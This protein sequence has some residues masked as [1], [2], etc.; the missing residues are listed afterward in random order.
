MPIFAY[1]VRPGFE[2]VRADFE[3]ALLQD[4][5]HRADSHRQ[6]A[7]LRKL[8]TLLRECEE[9]LNVALK[10]AQA[11]D[12]DRQLLKERI[13]GQ[14]SAV[15]DLKLA[16]HLAVKHA[17]A[18]TRVLNEKILG[19]HEPE[20]NTWLLQQFE[21]LF[22]QWTISLKYAAEMF[23]AWLHSALSERMAALSL[24]I[25]MISPNLFTASAGNYRSR[26]KISGIGS[27][28]RRSR[29]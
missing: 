7:L 28:M 10:S 11:A 17:K 19:K 24:C 12:S 8:E 20:L 23:E 6:A 5:L 4:S 15:Q 16:L 14:P 2:S 26:F 21:A 18:N 9:Y 13:L 27:P 29:P 1:S 3:R 25:E 22:P